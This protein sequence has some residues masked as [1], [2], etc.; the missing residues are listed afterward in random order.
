MR[1]SLLKLANRTTLEVMQSIT[2]NQELIGVLLGQYGDYGLPPAQSSFA[3]HAMVAGHYM[4]GGC[5]PIGGSGR[6]V[7]TVAPVIAESGGIVLTNADVQEII[8]KNNKAIGVK[9]ADGK[10]ITAPLIISSA[11]IINTYAHLLPDTVVKKHKLKQQLQ[12]VRPSVSHLCLYTGWKYTPEELQTDKPNLWIYPSY[13]HDKNVA[14]YLAD[15]NAPLP[16]VYVSFPSA[17]DPDWLNRY[18]GK[19]AIDLITLAPYEWFVQWEDKKWKKRGEDYEA[20]KEQFAQRLLAALYKQLPQLEGK[21][22]Y[23]ELS[24]PLTTKHF[25]NYDKGELYGLDHHPERFQQKFLRPHTPVK[26]L[27]LT[28]QDIV[29]AGVG[30]ALIGGALTISAIMKKD[31]LTMVRK[32]VEQAS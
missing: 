4:N 23:Y 6:I 7:E 19:S 26:N 12:K 32:R 18:P 27:Y 13:D 15:P 1:K 17:K 16:V 28:G 30:G 2:N 9:M 5:Y 20:F 14:D 11:G 31:I 25:A 24:S 21:L 10:E 22:D 29:S 3:I 8:V